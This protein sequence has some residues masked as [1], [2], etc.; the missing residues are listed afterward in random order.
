MPIGTGKIKVAFIQLNVIEG[1]EFHIF[2]EAVPTMLHLKE[3]DF[4]WL[5]IVIRKCHTFVATRNKSL[6][7]EN[8]FL[9]YI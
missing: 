7:V 6:S 2:S 9:I 4:N 5:Y 3:K 8:N 1:I